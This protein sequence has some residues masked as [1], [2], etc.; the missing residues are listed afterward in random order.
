MAENING[1]SPAAAAKTSQS[2][3]SAVI[4]RMSYTEFLDTSPLNGYLLLVVL[5]VSVAQMLDG[6]DFQSTSFALPLIVREFKLTPTQAGT[7]GSTTNLGIMIGSLIS[8]FLSDRFGRR[9]ILQWVLFTYSFGTLLSAIAGSYQFLLLARLI[10][11]LGIGAEHPVAVALLAEYSPK[12]LRHIIVPLSP[13]FYGIGWSLCALLATLIVPKFGWRGIYWVGVT[14]ALVILYVRRYMPESVRYLLQRGRIQE[15]GETTRKIADKAGFADVELVPPEMAKA[16]KKP[17]LAEQLHSLRY[18]A[19]TAIV[20]GFFYVA[21]HIQNVGFNA[22]LPSIFVKQGFTLLRSYQFTTLSLVVVPI[23]QLGAMWL[24][25]KMPRKWA[26]LLIAAIT[27]CSFFALGFSFEMKYPIA[28]IVGCSMAY[29]FFANAIVPILYTL[30]AELFPTR[31]RSLGIGVVSAFSRTGSIVGPVAIGLF[32]SFGTAIH[33]I[34]Y[35]FAI[36]LAVAAILGIVLIKVDSR[37]KALEQVT[38]A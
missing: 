32:M 26:V 7:L 28:V 14:P 1:T 30:S 25:D 20:L 13:W 8:G 37:Q 2:A 5:G 15:A 12:R 4:R 34:I 22:W 11:G 18:F 3:T 33:Q 24:Q 19:S 27:S 17:T 9:P 35:Y 23:G 21:F 31:V 38:G 6:M 29:Q 36:P 16:E 10:A